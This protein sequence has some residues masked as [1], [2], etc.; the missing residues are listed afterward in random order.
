M[1]GIVTYL[2]KSKAYSICILI[3]PIFGAFNLSNNTKYGLEY[4]TILFYFFFHF[5]SFSYH[6][7]SQY[8]FYLHKGDNGNY[9]YLNPFFSDSLNLQS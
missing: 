5:Y 9:I 8:I 6:S 2:Q 1:Q 4:A 3:Y 7:K